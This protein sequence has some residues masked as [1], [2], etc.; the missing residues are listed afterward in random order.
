MKAIVKKSAVSGTIAAPASKSFMHRALICSA[1][2]KCSTEL[3]PTCYGDDVLCTMSCLES[4]GA[5]FQIDGEKLIVHP[6]KE[7]PK[8]ILLNCGESGSTLRFLLPLICALGINGEFVGSGRLPER[9]IAELLQALKENGAA[10]S[11]NRLPFNVQGQ[12]KPGAYS[13]SGNVSSQFVSG[14]LMALPLLSGESELKITTALSAPGYVDITR[15]V[16]KEFS[17]HTEKISGGYSIC[18]AQAYVSP[19]RYK[20]EG[21]WSSAAYIL[22]AGGLCG[23][24]SVSNLNKKSRQADAAVMGLLKSM[25]AELNI[26]G[27]NITSSSKGRPLPIDLDVSD[28]PDLVPALAAFLS[29]AGGTSRLYNAGKLRFK[30]S[31]RLKTVEGMINAMGG[32]ARVVDD[33]LIIHGGGLKGGFIDPQGDHRIAMAAAIAALDSDGETQIA[34]AQCVSKSYPG[35]FKDL[36]K[37]GA[38]VEFID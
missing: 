16:M 37:L 25:D 5:E 36:K 13:V 4:L 26:A 3:F 2:C 35:F 7:I 12:I 34:D 17:V 15:Q 32:R 23:N 9:P 14:L 33:S 28:F 24:C 38:D 20:V 31:D 8:N 30:E 6:I 10:C 22:L 29:H 11:S 18:G 21:D 19:R 27:E 1:L